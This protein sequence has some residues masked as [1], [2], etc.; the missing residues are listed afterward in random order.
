MDK[1]RHTHVKVSLLGVVRTSPC[2]ISS[3]DPSSLDR[4]HHHFAQHRHL[5]VSFILTVV[6]M[7]IPPIEA[8][9]TE[10]S[11]LKLLGYLRRTATDSLA[12]IPTVDPLEQLNPAVHSLGYLFILYCPLIQMIIAGKRD[13]RLDSTTA[14]TR[15]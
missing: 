2:P 3:H 5:S 13:S 14:R 7:A 4:H 15:I 1:L 12:S 9:L 11:P 10:H 8:I 6:T